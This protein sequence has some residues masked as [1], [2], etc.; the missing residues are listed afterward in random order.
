MIEEIVEK[1]LP[2]RVEHVG[3]LAD[4]IYLD[5]ATVEP[6]TVKVSGTASVMEQAAYA[7]VKL[8]AS[9]LTA[10]YSGPASMCSR[11]K[12]ATCWSPNLRGI[13]TRR[14]RSTSRF[15]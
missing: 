13:L 9:D 15:T 6:A 8:D 10:D 12:R 7:V 11:M 3:A 5:E 1:E 14:C 4:G 2:V